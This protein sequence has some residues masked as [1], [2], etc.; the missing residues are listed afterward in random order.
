LV[1]LAVALLYRFSSYDLTKEI[2]MFPLSERVK[3]VADSITLAVSAKA[4]AL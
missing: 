1:A 3:Q 2:A 4:N